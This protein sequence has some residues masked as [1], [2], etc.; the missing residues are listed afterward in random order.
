MDN[1]IRL[2]TEKLENEGHSINRIFLGDKPYYR[3]DDGLAITGKQMR[4]LADGV[5]SF[6]ELTDDLLDRRRSEEEG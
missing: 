3:I 2:A 4:D 6:A 5:Y 1:R